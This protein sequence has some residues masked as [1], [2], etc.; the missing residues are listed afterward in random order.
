MVEGIALGEYLLVALPPALHL[1][2]FPERGGAPVVDEDIV[3]ADV[4]QPEER[5]ALAEVDLLAVPGREGLVEVAHQV[6][7]HPLDVHAVTD[8]GRQRRS[9]ASR[10]GRHRD[11]RGLGREP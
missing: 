2:R 6:E 10:L 9:M 4:S 3:G 5:A 7:S 11:G 8:T 1:R